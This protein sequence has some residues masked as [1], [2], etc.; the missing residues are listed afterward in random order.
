M[1]GK[2]V[3][4]KAM[5]KINT[6]HGK[7][8]PHIRTRKQFSQPLKAHYLHSYSMVLVSTTVQE[9]EIKGLTIGKKVK[10]SLFVDN[11]YIDRKPKGIYKCTMR[12]K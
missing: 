5:D 8:I 4:E 12:A 1:K 7:N 3:A 9:K 6:F 10:L 11:D 2:K